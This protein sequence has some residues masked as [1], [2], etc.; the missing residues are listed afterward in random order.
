MEDFNDLE[1]RLAALEQLAQAQ[2]EK[3][4]QAQ[5]A[6]ALQSI[7][8]QY[9][10]RFNNRDDV[11]MEILNQLARKG[12]DVSAASSNAVQDILDDMQAQVA[13]LY[14]DFNQQKHEMQE[15]QNQAAEL[16]DQLNQIDETVK[17]ATGG[18]MVNDEVPPP[19]EEAPVPEAP[20]TEPVGEPAVPPVEEAP[21]PVPEE[22]AP[23]PVPAPA[24]MAPPAPEPVTSDVTLKNVETPNPMG[25]NQSFF[26]KK[27]NKVNVAPSPAILSDATMKKP[28]FGRN[29]IDIARRGW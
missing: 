4:A 3:E 28:S 12:V 22:P 2:Q 15:T 25:N 16:A 11:G 13:Q 10:M 18:D 5:Q 6:A 19:V 8:D 17:A 23:E 27:T 21:A 14:D 29:L 1:P 7:K 9:G 26:I 24:D 20:A